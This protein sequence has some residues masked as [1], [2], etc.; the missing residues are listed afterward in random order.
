MLDS[1]GDAE[2]MCIALSRAVRMIAGARASISI[3]TAVPQEI[4]AIEDDVVA[5]RN[6]FEHIDERAVGKAH[7]EGQHDAMSVFDQSDFFASGVLRYA[8]RSLDTCDEV[9]PALISG[10][11]FILE[12]AAQAGLTKTITEPIKWDFTPE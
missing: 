5:I 11:R 12:A 8:G 9:M 2:S 1:L 4:N 7:R 10:R 6:A 3:P